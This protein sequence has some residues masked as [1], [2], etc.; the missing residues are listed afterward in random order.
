MTQ[1]EQVSIVREPHGWIVQ[2][3]HVK[4]ARLC[5]QSRDREYYVKGAMPVSEYARVCNIVCNHEIAHGGR[6][7]NV[8]RAGK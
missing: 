6:A 5:W 7:I 2:D 3:G 8:K 1:T 4:G